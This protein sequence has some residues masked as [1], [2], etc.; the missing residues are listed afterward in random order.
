MLT[1]SIPAL[2]GHLLAATLF[3]AEGVSGP[4]E[5]DAANAVAEKPDAGLLKRDGAGDV[6]A[7]VGKSISGAEEN[8][9][10]SAHAG[11][12]PGAGEDSLDSD[13]AFMADGADN[14]PIILLS[15]GVAIPRGFYDKF[16]HWLVKRGAGAV[17]TWDYRGIGDSWPDSGPNTGPDS[18]PD[19]GQVQKRAFQYK[20]SDWVRL[21]FPA[22]IEWIRAHYPDRPIYAIGHSF[23]GQ[24]FGLVECNQYVEK[25][26]TIASM[27]GYWRKMDF[28]DNYKAYLSL[29]VIGPLVGRIYGYIPGKFGLGEDLS[30]AAHAE[31]AGWCRNKNY[32]FDDPNMVETRHFAAYKGPVLAIGLDDDTWATP[33]L[34]DHLVDHFTNAKLERWQLSSADFDVQTGAKVGHFG[35]FKQRFEQPLWDPLGDWL[36]GAKV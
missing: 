11:G 22:V 15:S 5:L 34:I 28:P 36:F 19:T 16:A 4:A 9:L 23:G 24:V 27:S 21:D 12:L 26:V 8:D 25:A 17:I 3:E 30:R 1:V 35:F 13:A 20:M 2:D 7:G 31:W 14:S 10:R 33:E 6:H 18:G 32:F 29:C